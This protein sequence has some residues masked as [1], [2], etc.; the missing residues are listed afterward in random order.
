[1]KLN[2]N[3]ILFVAK[4][5][6]VGNISVMPGTFGTL[7]GI[8]ICFLLS[9]LN[10]PA[11]LPFQALF[12]IAFILFSV[13]IA[14]EAVNIL[15]QKDPGCIVID[16]IAGFTVTMIGVGFSVTSVILAFIAF[17]FFDILKPFPVKFLEE[18]VPGGA[19]VV[20]DD[21]AAGI[22]ANIVLRIILAVFGI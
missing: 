19:G 10:T 1:M 5:C 21:I 13:W 16:E 6:N 7:V 15:N 22:M 2:E 3:Q 9:F 4:G 14:E 17:R 18:K 8:P 20:L 11:G 12:A